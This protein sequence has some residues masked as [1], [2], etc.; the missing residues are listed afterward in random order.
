VSD[1][2]LRDYLEHLFEE[3]EKR[4]AREHEDA[5][6]ALEEARRVLDLRLGEL[7]NLR[8]E[9]T[10]D[11]G[12]LVQRQLFDSRM[13]T[14]DNAIKAVGSEVGEIRSELSGWRGRQAA[15]GV[16]ITVALVLVPLLI[17]IFIK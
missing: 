10:E 12:Q 7:N 11:R 1:I 3:H 17:N 15:F 8:R 9:Y 13:E 14:Q 2:S 16:V 4:H 6:R 5:M